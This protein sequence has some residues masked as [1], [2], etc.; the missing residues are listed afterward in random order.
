[1]GRVICKLESS[2]G[3]K[4]EVALLVLLSG[5]F[6]W[7]LNRVEDAVEGSGR[8]LAWRFGSFEVGM[9][10]SEDNGTLRICNTL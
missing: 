9:I 2:D 5:S 7:I 3:E 6:L 4:G 1:M 8:D 10:V